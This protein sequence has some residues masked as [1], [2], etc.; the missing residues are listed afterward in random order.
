MK[1]ML[2]LWIFHL[3]IFYVPGNNSTIAVKVMTD[4]FNCKEGIVI[5][6]QVRSLVEADSLLRMFNKNDSTYIIVEITSYQDGGTAVINAGFSMVTPIQKNKLDYK[7][8]RRLVSKTLVD[9]R[10][11]STNIVDKVHLI[12]KH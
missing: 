6:D 7:Y 8:S 10:N 9:M 5:A 1:I 12:R 3:L 2:S 4:G 11:I